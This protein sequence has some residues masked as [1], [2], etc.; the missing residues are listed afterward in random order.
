MSFDPAEGEHG[1]LAFAR[2]LGLTFP[3]I[4]DVGKNLSMLYG[5]AL[6][7]DQP[8]PARMSVLI[9]RDGIVRFVDRAVQVRTHGPDMLLKMRELG[10]K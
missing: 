5:S 7:A 9:D 8:A 4:P 3:L 10:M 6:S 1:Q 2:Q